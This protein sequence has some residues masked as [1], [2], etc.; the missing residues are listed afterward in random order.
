MIFQ[1]SIGLLYHFSNSKIYLI[2]ESTLI[3]NTYNLFSNLWSDWAPMLAHAA[4]GIKRPMFKRLM[5]TEIFLKSRGNPHPSQ[6]L[7]RTKQKFFMWKST[8]R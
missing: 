7:N 2:L 8:L 6:F 3:M 1:L 4:R 5:S